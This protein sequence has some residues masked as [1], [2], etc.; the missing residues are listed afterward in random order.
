MYN[1]KVIFR[2][3]LSNIADFLSRR[4]LKIKLEK[5]K[6]V[7]GANKLMVDEVS[8]S[9]PVSVAPKRSQRQAKMVI[10]EV[11][12]KMIEREPYKM[13]LAEIAAETKADVVLNE[14]IGKYRSIKKNKNLKDFRF[15]SLVN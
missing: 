15:L 13:S 10:R 5:D 6:V 7:G 9:K 3:G 2:Q 14:A 8:Q 11:S 12:T 1:A 4:S